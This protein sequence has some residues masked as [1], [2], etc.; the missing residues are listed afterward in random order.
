MQEREGGMRRGRTSGRL[1]YRNGCSIDWPDG[2]YTLITS[3]DRFAFNAG[4]GTVTFNNA[5]IDTAADYSPTGVLERSGR[6]NSVEHFTV[7]NGV[8][9]RV[10]FDFEHFHGM[11]C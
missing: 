1:L 5:H 8:I 7:T 2:S 9:V 6:L 10:N 3:F 11:F 4:T